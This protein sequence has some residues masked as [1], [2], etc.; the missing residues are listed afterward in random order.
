MTEVELVVLG[1]V[2]EGAE[3]A[4]EVE[5]RIRERRLR[6]WAAIGFSSV[7]YLLQRAEK[8][9][10]LRSR[11][12]P[13]RRGPRIRRYTLTARGRAELRAA[14]LA[15]L[16]GLP[17]PGGVEL[18]VMFAGAVPAAEFRRALADYADRCREAAAGT[19]A[20]W[21]GLPSSP[22]RAQQDAIFDHA[23]TLLEAE[24]AWAERTVERLASSP[25]AGGTSWQGGP[26]QKEGPCD[27]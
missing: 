2:Q 23:V 13:G 12:A 16:G 17:A 10:W 27:E 11:E 20:R 21:A 1:L 22:Y 8:A 18:T 4:Y 6:E 3:Y 26:P 14:V 9:G 25:N 19:R 5:Q 15:R 7:Y 24:A